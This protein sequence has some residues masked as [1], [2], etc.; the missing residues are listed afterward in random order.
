MRLRTFTA[1]SMPAAMKMVRS[2]LG[3][4]AVIISS[5]PLNGSKM[6]NVTAAIDH[7]DETHAGGKAQRDPA[8]D[9]LRFDLQNIL[10]FHNLP[11]LFIAKL[12]QHAT[13]DSLASALALH[14]L[15]GPHD[16]RQLHKLALESLMQ[17][18][19]TCDPLLDDARDRRLMLVG[20][21]GIG[22][23]LTIAKIATR[24]SLDRHKPA[25]I[26]TD[27][28]RA[29]GVEQLRAFTDILGIPLMVASSR[30]E[31]LTHLK[32]VPAKQRAL[33][34]TAGCNA[35]D[36]EQ[37][38]ELKS[39]T[40]IE[41]VEPVLALPAGGDSMEM[42]DIGEMF[43]ALPLKRLLI[44]RADTARRFGGVLAVAAAHGLSFC[45]V[46]NSSSV[47]GPLNAADAGLLA[48]LLLRYQLQTL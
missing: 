9:N 28:K 23:T 26:T 46:S 2:A 48:Q 21:P 1:P 20:P 24:L 33:I 11:E 39:Y 37:M 41:G 4:D 30:T 38:Q 43:M 32:S 13:D 10:R 22:K 42:I 47:T 3:D 19:F 17:S 36:G 6:I 5:E 29:G 27:T 7:D 40:T 25:V 35:Y 16:Q 31:L 44:T 45:H 18:Y 14:R 12:I 15:S 8:L 34:D